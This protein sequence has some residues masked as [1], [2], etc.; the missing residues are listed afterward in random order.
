MPQVANTSSMIMIKDTLRT[1]KQI[2]K[3]F[4][5]AFTLAVHCV[6]TITRCCCCYMLG[7][8]VI[9]DLRITIT[10]FVFVSFLFVFV[11]VFSLIFLMTSFSSSKKFLK[12]NPVRGR[13]K[14]HTYIISCK[15]CCK[16]L[17]CLK[18]SSDELCGLL[19]VFF[20]RTFDSGLY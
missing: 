13:G 7:N 15:V 3:L 17:S 19:K 11:F 8:L 2:P 16:F 10:Q 4:S 1:H 6:Y 5:Q 9:A 14:G 12:G 18:F 20:C